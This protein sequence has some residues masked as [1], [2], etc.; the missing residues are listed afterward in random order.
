[1]PNEK[2]MI[3]R[4]SRFKDEFRRAGFSPDEKHR[5]F[6]SIK[7]DASK[8]SVCFIGLN[9]STATE[10]IDDPTIRRC[11]GFAKS[12]G[13]GGIVMKNIFAFRATDPKDMKAAA[14][15]VGKL[16]TTEFLKGR[17]VGQFVIGAW[18][19]HGNFQD[20]SKIVA[21]GFLEYPKKEL[22]A[23]KVTQSG[24]PSHPLYLKGDLKPRLYVDLIRE[25]D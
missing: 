21:E 24:E 7:W 5:Y 8:A 15:P 1:M 4:E 25:N 12:W 17:S 3:V 6:L 2:G 16:N 20:R 14:D 9:P 18:G 11:K 19:N 22:H 10:M 23:L 13:Y